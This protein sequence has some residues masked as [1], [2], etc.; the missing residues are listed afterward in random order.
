M[1]KFNFT[2]LILLVVF[3]LFAQVSMS[4]IPDPPQEWLDSYLENVKFPADAPGGLCPQPKQEPPLFSTEQSTITLDGV[5]LEVGDWVAVFYN[6]G[7][8]RYCACLVPYKTGNLNYGVTLTQNGEPYAYS[9]NANGSIIF[10]S[11]YKDSYVSACGCT[12]TFYDGCDVRVVDNIYVYSNSKGVYGKVNSENFTA[13]PAFSFSNPMLFNP[14]WNGADGKFYARIPGSNAGSGPF[15]G[16]SKM[17]AFTKPVDFT[18]KG[19][20]LDGNSS[21]LGGFTVACNGTTGTTAADGSFTITNVAIDNYNGTITF[22]NMPCYNAYVVTDPKYPYGEDDFPTTIDLG[23]IIYPNSINLFSISGEVDLGG[24]YEYPY[25][26]KLYDDNDVLVATIASPEPMTGE[27]IPYEFT[28]VE[29]GFTGYITIV[30]EA[31]NF[32]SGTIAIASLEANSTGNDFNGVI[33]TYTVSLSVEEGEE[34]LASFPLLVNEAA[35]TTGEDGSAYVATVNY[36][37]DLYAIP[38]DNHYTYTPE[39]VTYESITENKEQVFT[40][41]HKMVNL[42]GT[43][44]FDGNGLADITINVYADGAVIATAVTDAE[45]AYTFTQK[46]GHSYNVVAE[47]E[48]YYFA[49]Q[50]YILENITES[51]DDLNFNATRN[52]FKVSGTVTVNGEPLAGITITLL[53]TNFTATT[54]EDGT[55]MFGVVPYGTS[56]T[57]APVSEA[58]TFEPDAIVFNSIED[59]LIDNDFAAT[60]NVY[61]ITTTAG[62]NGSITPAFAEVEHGGSAM[63]TITPNEGYAIQQVIVD[64]EIV[65]IEG[66][67][68]EFVN[69][70]SNH[71]ISAFFSLIKFDIN[72]K[73]VASQNGQ[74]LAGVTL[75]HNSGVTAVTAADGTFTFVDVVSY[76]D[77]NYTITGNVEGYEPINYSVDGEFREDITDVVI[78]AQ[79]IYFEISGAVSF[80]WLDAEQPW[81]PI[82]ELTVNFSGLNPVTTVNGVYSITVEYGYTGTAVPVLDGFNILPIS[83]NYANVT[84]GIDEQNYVA[85]EIPPIY[86]TISGHVYDNNNEPIEGAKVVF[87]NFRSNEV[88]GTTDAEGFYSVELY[89]TWT[90]MA[91]AYCSRNLQFNDYMLTIAGTIE[92]LDFHGEQ[93]VCPWGP[94][95]ISPIF[96]QVYG[97][98]GE[99]TATLNGIS[100]RSGDWIGAFYTDENGELQFSGS[101]ALWKGN[102]VTLD[103]PVYGT[104]TGITSF[105]QGDSI[106]YKVYSRAAATEYLVEDVEYYGCPYH[107]FPSCSDDGLFCNHCFSG[108]KNMT[109]TTET[110]TISGTVTVDGEPLNGATIFTESGSTRTDINGNYTIT[111]VGN[112]AGILTAGYAGYIFTPVSYDFAETPVKANVDGYDYTAEVVY[113]TVSGTVTNEGAAVEGANILVN[114]LSLTTTD[115]S[116]AYTI[117]V[118]YAF[119]G[120]IEAFLAPYTIEPVYTY[121][122]ENSIKTNLEGVNFTVTAGGFSGWEYIPTQYQHT[123]LFPPELVPTINGAAIQDGDW[124]GAFF[125]NDEGDLQC[126]GFLEWHANT[127]TNQSLVAYGEQVVPGG[128]TLPGFNIGEAFNFVIHS[129]VLN[130]DITVTSE[131]SF[132]DCDDV[133]WNANPVVNCV[134]EPVFAYVSDLIT[135]SEVNSLKLV[136]EESVKIYGTIATAENVGIEGVNLYIDGAVVAESG[137]NGFYMV[138]VPYGSSVTVTPKLTRYSFTPEEAEFTNL[139]ADVNQD[140]VAEYMLIPEGW[141]HDGDFSKFHNV[142]IPIDPANPRINGIAL[143]YGDFIGAFYYDEETGEERCGGYTEWKPDGN[144]LYRINVMLKGDNNP[145]LSEW[146]KNGFAMGEEFR[147]RIYCWTDE[148]Q[149]EAIATYLTRLTPLPPYVDGK[150]AH[151]S[152]SYIN[153]LSSDQI[154]V[155]ASATPEIACGGNTIELTAVAS[156]ANGIYNYEWT[157]NNGTVITNANTA[158]ASAVLSETTTFTVRAYT[159]LNEATASV[160]VVRYA[161]V[162]ATLTSGQNQTV[163]AATDAEVIT[164]APAGGEGSVTSNYWIMWQMSAD[165][166]EYTNLLE[167]KT[168]NA[169]TY[170]PTAMPEGTYYYRALVFDVCSMEEGTP[171]DVATVEWK[172]AVVV[173]INNEPETICYNAEAFTMLTATTVGNI[174]DVVYTWTVNGEEVQSGADNTYTPTGAVVAEAGTYTIAV[175]VENQCG[176]NE[177]SIELTRL[178]PMSVTLATADVNP[179]CSDVPFGEITATVIGTI[180]EINYVWAVNGVAVEGANASTFTP[181]LPEVGTYVVSVVATNA[182]GEVT[183]EVTI[184]RANPVAVVIDGG[185]QAIC[186]GGTFETLTALTSGGFGEY[187][188]QWYVDGEEVDATEATYT[189]ELPEA[190]TYTVTVAVE[191]ACIAEPLYAEE[192]VIIRYA[193]FEGGITTEDYQICNNG[194]FTAIETAFE[195]GAG[196]YVYSWYMTE[197]EE[198]GDEATFTPEGEAF[199]A[200]GVYT[201]YVTVTDACGTITDNIVI[202]RLAAPTVTIAAAQTICAGET[203]EPLTV[204]VNNVIGDYELIWLLNSEIIEGVTG[205]TYQPTEPGYYGV[206]L[207]TG[208]A[209]GLVQSMSILLI[210]YE[211][212]VVDYIAPT[213]TYYCADVTEVAP[214]TI[215]PT[216]GDGIYQI[217]WQTKVDG[218]WTTQQEGGFTFA[219]AIPDNNQMTIIECRV[220]IDSDFCSEHAEFS[221]TYYFYAPFVVSLQVPEDLTYCYASEAEPMTLT[222]NGGTENYQIRWEQKVSMSEWTT[223]QTG[224]YTFTPQM[225][226][227]GTQTYRVIV[228]D[229]CGFYVSSEVTYTWHND[230]VLTIAIEG[231]QVICYNETFGTLSSTVTN[232]Y[233]EVS[234]Q[235]YLN[236]EVIEGATNATYEPGQQ[237]G[238]YT[239]QIADVKCGT[240]T[241]NAIVLER[242]ANLVVDLAIAEDITNICNEETFGTLTATVAGGMGVYTYAWSLNGEVIEG[243]T[244]ATYEPGQVAG[245]YVVSVSDSECGTVTDAITLFRADVVTSAIE[246]EAEVICYE[247]TFA[248]L[249]AVAAGGFVED[250]YTYQWQVNGVNIEGE[251]AATYLPVLEP[252]VYAI[253]VVVYNTCATTGVESA[254]VTLERKAELLISIAEPQV[255]CSGASFAELTATAEGGYEGE[256]TYQWFL[257]GEAIDGAVAATYLPADSGIYTAEVYNTCGT[258]T[259]NAVLLEYKDP[260]VATIA[261]SQ[262]I[263]N[264][265]VFAEIVSTVS[266]GFGDYTYAWYE[267]VEGENVALGVTTAN[268]TTQEAGTYFVEVTDSECG[269]IA[270]NTVVLYRADAVTI[271]FENANQ[272]ICYSGEI[273]PLTVS[274]AGGLGD[275]TYQWYVDGEAVTGANGTTYTPELPEAGTYEI[276]VSVDN[277]CLAEPMF[278]E[279]S[280]TIIRY[281]TFEGG[282]TTE[283]Y[284]ICNNGDFTKI[285]TA[286]EGGAGSYVYSWYI[287]EGEELGNEATFTPEGETFAAVGVYTI[288]V[289]VTD[290]CGTIT[291]NIVVERLAAPTV[292]IAEAQTICAG[293]TFAPLTATIANVLGDYSLVWLYNS[294]TIAGA[295]GLTYQPTEPGY[296]G[297]LLFTECTDNIF[298]ES[299]SIELIRYELMNVAYTAPEK[300]TYCAYELDVDPMEIAP[301][302]ADG[303]YEILWQTKVEGEWETQQEGGYTF[304]PTRPDVNTAAVV[305]CRVIVNNEYCDEHAEFSATYYFYAP[306]VASLAIPEDLMFCYAAV[307]DPMV[308]TVNGGTENYQIRWEQK[309]S[310]SEWRLVQAGG[311]TY[312]PQMETPGTQTYRVI[313][314]D[315]CGFFVSS[316]INYTWYEDIVVTIAIEGD[317][318]ICYDETFGTLSSTVANSYNEIS[319][320]WYLNGTAIEGATN[321]T[322]EPGQQDGTYTLQIVDVKCGLV[323]SN[324]IVLERKAELAVDLTITDGITNICNEETFGTLTANVIGGMGIYTYAWSLDGVAIEGAAAATYEPGQVD[325]EYVVVVTDSECGTVSDTITL[326]RAEVVTVAIEGEDQVVCYD[327]DFAQLTAIAAGGFVE[328]GYAYQWKDNGNDI[329]GANDATYLPV[330]EPGVHAV[331]VVVYNTC[332]PLGVES[333]AITLERKAELLINIA[334]AQVLCSGEPFAEITATAQGGYEGEYTYQ[335]FLNGVAIDGAVAATYL[336]AD[337]GTYTAEVYNTCGTAVS[338]AILLEYKDPFVATIAAS[339]DICI[340]GT[341]EEIVSTVSGGFGDYTYAWYEVVEGENVALDV[342]TANYT[343]QEAGTYILEVTDSECGTIFTNTV[344]LYRADEVTITFENANQT[345]CYVEA[346]APLTVSAA[347]GLGGYTYQWYVNDVAVAGAT[348]ATYTPE[349]P[350]AGTSL[351]KVEV[352]NVCRV[353][354]SSEVTL[355]RHEGLT[356]ENIADQFVCDGNLAETMTIVAHG[357]SNN[358]ISYSWTLNG[359]VVST[360]ASY[361]PVRSENFVGVD[362]YTATAT[363]E[364]C[365]D[366]SVEVEVRW[367]GQIGVDV[368]IN[369]TIYTQYVYCVNAAPAEMFAQTLYDADRYTYQWQINIEG[370]WYNVFGATAA[371]Y[372]PAAPITGVGEVSYAVLI[373]SFDGCG[374]DIAYITLVWNEAI[375]ATISADQTICENGTFDELVSVVEGDLGE[376]PAYQWY[377]NGTAIEGAVEAA[378]LPTEAGDYYLVIESACGTITTNT[379][380]LVIEA[381]PTVFAGDNGEGCYNQPYQITGGTATNYA[382][383]RWTT[384]GNGSFSSLTELNPTYTPGRYDKEMGTVELTLTASGNGICEAVVSTLTLTVDARPDTPASIE[385]PDVVIGDVT[386]V[387]SVEAVEGVSYE[388]FIYPASAGTIEGN[389]ATATVTWSTDLVKAIKA[390]ISVQASNECGM[391][392]ITLKTVR[393]TPVIGNND[394]DDSSLG[395]VATGISVNVYPNPTDGKFTVAAEGMTGSYEVVIINYAGQVVYR[396][397]VTADGTMTQDF[398]LS[399]KASGVYFVRI[400]N[401]TDNVVKRIILN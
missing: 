114:G 74:P 193:A 210:R 37:S 352:T 117:T 13:A 46:W 140:F 158:N 346:F 243:A 29:C 152:F 347:G 112:W 68:Y 297:I 333:V 139:T 369:G 177:A 376:T 69:V 271:T 90:G 75:T 149:Y 206:L 294:E 226:T 24:I 176:E 30:S 122:D 9:I 1:K 62:E 32:E 301:T 237:D 275:Y 370:A 328:D 308:L 338:N 38:N 273:V 202:E 396:D 207:S 201:I 189:P 66:N 153:D 401:A 64:N 247:G 335:W 229:G 291:D 107:S 126:A 85:T 143:E 180:G 31:Y 345:I 288:Y 281:A 215:I 212:M 265:A 279:G 142:I 304:T 163:C 134:G 196:N 56:A 96:H 5:E 25:T 227:P 146:T 260:F 100:L 222:V 233:N 48:E 54:G 353:V 255:I 172:G 20:L 154:A 128:I 53:P 12:A 83:V 45:G 245:D 2:N 269:M 23:N 343:T 127:T 42:S 170:L 397:N 252:G 144:P 379:V 167:A 84:S 296:Y 208:C 365:G 26:L 106:I 264:D 145:G 197:G 258:A 262:D 65:A 232:S 15:Y 182:C 395:D 390:Q 217:L 86:Y 332:A 254:A 92:N 34:T 306:F 95:V 179:V 348:E 214:M 310:M 171:S 137:Y 389:G 61:T 190:G 77:D 194:E 337:S 257:N 238:T 253:T 289:A 223:V 321:A 94:I 115:A 355:I 63:F 200:V 211:Q 17:E 363:D 259:S 58:Y 374:G 241:S 380:T 160:E 334:E 318:V 124:I 183:D 375:A 261:A 209:N 377:L 340:D 71:S 82:P 216:G 327:V 3:M 309:V 39:D 341:F 188:Y 382:S 204:T 155:V 219:P 344:V 239:L 316:E 141:E 165:G 43:V 99:F 385:G 125:I 320:Q 7:D 322:Y 317:Q 22:S 33:K 10:G 313:V 331:T 168:L 73:L 35:V 47:S 21:P 97:V 198:L 101:A 199:A 11:Y 373:N 228:T 78:V 361:T 221:A 51:R 378:Y 79:R 381:A 278:A 220:T 55:Y 250:G 181:E 240:V 8:T 251:T 205:L 383:L 349:L 399:S 398:D 305:E 169:F 59:D 105:N 282:I 276:T 319:Y 81:D 72:G 218:E 342:T 362:V 166:A 178:V 28:D 113:F 393:Y 330:L 324:A 307:P 135:M 213:Q 248:Q 277:Q 231:D 103:L 224:G 371:T 108:L 242:K 234:Y 174:G 119:E 394:G 256:Y 302:G 76:F 4:Q 186:Y 372:T 91:N 129:N 89:E 40:A 368:T 225:A 364:Q 44:S 314:N 102:V 121:T 49:P 132:K 312:T 235:W 391:S 104:A 357:G 298:V 111:V 268:Y 162:T 359:E 157:S 280:V 283:D 41:V 120:T 184:I 6:D 350:E 323:S 88:I 360:E 133:I 195:G 303:I 293:E 290:A 150:F 116:G 164:V 148:A 19:I 367:L 299:N 156:G 358:F 109:A 185:G 161:D 159:T 60:I 203:F 266:G 14:H 57:I 351:V 392:G 18:L 329:A 130:A 249:T 400:F 272:N 386:T 325:G 147:W 110:Y 274:A 366:V 27:V 52:T 292:T 246:G 311:Y 236:G 285:E 339:Q 336:P 136:T 131:I 187:T 286:F 118:P 123:V 50:Q 263:C 151:Q 315:N 300:T 98:A 138:E 70:V 384:N 244:A 16:Y 192:V 326:F 295:T 230:I 191:N 388:W 87:D 175:T 270:T 287:T 284:Q 80:V 387:Y 173:T 356:I 36:G 354:M 93:A 67:T 267:V